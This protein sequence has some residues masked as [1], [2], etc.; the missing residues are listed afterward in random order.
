VVL[1]AVLA[2][3]AASAIAYA[4]GVDLSHWQGSV[5]WSRVKGDDVTFAFMK[6]TEGEYYTDP[7]LAKNWAGA[8]KVGIYRAA[9]HFA[10]PSLAAGSAARQARYFVSK[11]GTFADKGDLPPVLDLEA[12][13]GLSPAALRSWVSTWLTTTESLTGRRPI[14]YF[15]PYFWI[16]HLG[17]STAFTKYPLWIAHYTTGAPK[18]PGGWPTWTFWQRT[19]SGSVDGISGHVDM[20]RFNGTSAQLAALARSTGGSDAPAPSGPTLPG[21]VA[22]SLTMAPATTAPAYDDD[23]AFTGSLV[24]TSPASVLAHQPV[25]LWSRPAGW[26]TWRRAAVGS[27]DGSGRYTLSAHVRRTAD[28]Q[29]RFAAD[30]THSASVS[31]ISRLTTPPRTAVRIDLLKNRTTVRKGAALMLY[32]HLTAGENGV[33]GETVRYYK[34]MPSGRTW[35][36]VGSSTS[37]APT[38]WH[39]LTVHPRV[40][41][42]WKVVYS[43]S[44]HYAPERSHYLRVHVR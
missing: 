16:D 32:G 4:D 20:N 10:R 37:L 40:N 5:N 13:G 11:A 39:S 7:T 26:V 19:S 2:T 30:S 33:A 14:L 31:P 42:V 43:G 22:T 34:R 29:V 18:I 24:Q 3:F 12:T 6:A 17:N 21:G 23:V 1:V 36:L 28:Y 9:Y 41:R 38:G 44:S 27:T 25:S 35:T 15:S 8:E